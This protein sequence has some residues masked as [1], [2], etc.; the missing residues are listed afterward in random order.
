MDGNTKKWKPNKIRKLRFSFLC[1]AYIAYVIVGAAVFQAIEGPQEEDEHRVL[2]EI[3][4]D[5]S[6]NISA[7]ITGMSRSA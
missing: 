3:V 5:F 1:L 7:C 6:Q 4:F 2:Q